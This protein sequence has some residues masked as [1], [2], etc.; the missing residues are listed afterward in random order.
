[1]FADI[2]AQPGAAQKRH[3]GQ[4][5]QV[6]QPVTFVLP[7]GSTPGEAPGVT[8]P[9]STTQAAPDSSA[10]PSSSKGFAHR[11]IRYMVD[12]ISP[13]ESATI[14]MTIIKFVVCCGLSFKTVESPFFL[15]MIKQLRPAFMP[16]MKGRTYFS[17]T[18]LD[19][20]HAEVMA[21]LE[22]EFKKDGGLF[23]LAGDG[24][25]AVKGDKVC[26]FSEQQ[27]DRVAYK[28]SVEAMPMNKRRR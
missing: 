13:Q 24:W 6:L 26:N 19:G 8:A 14:L 23:T 1:M 20:L 25:K 11:D 7:D 17:T 12:R 28:N 21:R 27:G 9:G 15:D 16:H 3:L 18:A 22:A 2:L 10:A 4:Q 5:A